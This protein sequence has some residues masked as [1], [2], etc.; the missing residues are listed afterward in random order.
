MRLA[1]RDFFA[2]RESVLSYGWSWLALPPAAEMKRDRF[3]PQMDL[4]LGK[5]IGIWQLGGTKEHSRQPGPHRTPSPVT[6]QLELRSTDPIHTNT[7]RLA[8]LPD[9][10]RQHGE[11]RKLRAGKRRLNPLQP[12]LAGENRNRAAVTVARE[13]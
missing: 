3:F 8:N 11:P 2:R 6:A 7:R 10:E 12:A 4:F 9:C 13:D 1:I 5:S